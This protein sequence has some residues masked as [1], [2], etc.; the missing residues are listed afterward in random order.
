LEDLRTRCA[1]VAEQLNTKLQ[2]V[3][4]GDIGDPSVWRGFKIAIKSM[5]K[6]NDIAEF[7]THLAIFT[8]EMQ[9]HILVDLR[10][11][12]IS[13]SELFLLTYLNKDWSIEPGI[14]AERT[15]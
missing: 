14:V 13:C 12:R 10:S 8:Q 7:Q 6:Q 9:L 2:S 4:L 5:W 1:V 11:V 15:I 3:S